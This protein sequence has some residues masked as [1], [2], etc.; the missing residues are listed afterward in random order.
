MTDALLVWFSEEVLTAAARRSQSSEN[1][2]LKSSFLG[3]F[4]A[5]AV[6]LLPQ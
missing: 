6:M 2:L 4:C 1:S 5:A 3:V